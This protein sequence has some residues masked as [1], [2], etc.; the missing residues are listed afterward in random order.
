MNYSNVSNFKESYIFHTQCFQGWWLRK[1]EGWYRT[2]VSLRVSFLKCRWHPL[3][4][5]HI[6]LFSQWVHIYVFN[7]YKQRFA[8]KQFSYL[9]EETTNWNKKTTH[10]KVISKTSVTIT[11]HSMEHCTTLSFLKQNKTTE[12]WWKCKRL[13]KWNFYQKELAIIES[14]SLEKIVVERNWII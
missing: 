4:A 2:T 11:L 7:F 10:C 1:N 5:V 13:T 8:L 9:G 3:N 6:Y 14:Y 12:V